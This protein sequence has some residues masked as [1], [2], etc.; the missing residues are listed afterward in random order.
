MTDKIKVLIANEEPIFRTGLNRLIADETDMQV[1][2]IAD[3]GEE[4]V[5]MAQALRPDVAIVD[6]KL[7]KLNGIE[8]TRQ[9]KAECPEVGIIILSG[10]HQLAYLLPAMRAG[11]ARYLLN[12]AAPNDVI[13]AIRWVHAKEEKPNLRAITR[14]LKGGQQMNSFGGLH[15]REQEVLKL[16]A[17]GLGTKA[18]ANRL[19]ISEHTV[20]NHLS[21]IYR[22]LGVKSRNQAVLFAFKEGFVTAEDLP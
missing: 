12:T 11:V 17:Q 14:L 5:L 18:I 7:A 15:R 16:A 4:A 21:G 2:A 22:T 8:V 9:I 6:L 1:V 13:D 19:H 10:P 20:K 3:D